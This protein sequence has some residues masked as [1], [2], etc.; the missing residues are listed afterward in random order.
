MNEPE[1]RLEPDEDGSTCGWCSIEYACWA[2]R[3]P[4][5]KKPRDPE[6]EAIVEQEMP[7]W[8]GGVSEAWMRDKL[9]RAVEA[10][11]EP[12]LKRIE[13]AE[14]KAE[15]YCRDWYAAKSEFGTAMAKMRAASSDKVR[16]LLKRYG[17]HLPECRAGTYRDE[18][19]CTCGLVEAVRDG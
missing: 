7:V 19:R 12:L 10:G 2:G 1:D 3:A 11:R 15:Q 14:S 17:A 8:C 4:C 5:Q 18:A 6:V 9:R 13:E 16:Q